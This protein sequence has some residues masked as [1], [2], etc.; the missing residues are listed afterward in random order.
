MG[1]T[2]YRFELDKLIEVSKKLEAPF[3]YEK[4]RFAR[5]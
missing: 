2:T 4:N 5:R 3:A 1:M